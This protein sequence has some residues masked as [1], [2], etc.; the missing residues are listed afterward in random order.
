V[1][2]Q[3]AAN[4]DVRPPVPVGEYQETALR[5]NAGYELAFE[6]ATA[7]LRAHCSADA[8]LL[9][10]GAGGGTEVRAFA[11]AGPGWHLTVVDPSA[12]M[13]ALA[14]AAAD[15]LGLAA[16]VRLV[17]GT[18]DDLPPAAQFDAATAF[19]VLMHLPD[20][21]GKLAALRGIRQRLKPGASLL[22][23][24]AVRDERAR[25]APAWQHY[26]EAR[27]M[28]AA[29]VAAL[30]AR[31]TASSNT[32]TEARELA[33]LEEVGFRDPRRFFA[34]LHINGWIATA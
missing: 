23:A 4:F 10:V 27:G 32:S 31:I 19:F 22:L 24:D 34:A 16:R 18:V 2:E 25:F 5:V 3:H 21:G 6:L 15:A 26:A 7:L 20:D 14:R 1:G 12:D 33:Q 17:R 8:R 29:E 9:L 11:P 28:P 30:I 13:L